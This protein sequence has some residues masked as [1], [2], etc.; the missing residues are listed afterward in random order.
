[1]KA[2]PNDPNSVKPVRTKQG[3]GSSF[4]SFI[5]CFF[6]RRYAYACT[7]KVD[8]YYNQCLQHI[9]FIFNFFEGVHPTFFPHSESNAIASGKDLLNE[10]D[11]AFLVVGSGGIRFLAWPP[12]RWRESVLS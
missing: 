7:D 3:G 10:D 8:Y 5:Y 11:R 4:I 9:F 12:R 6:R 1:M 2:D